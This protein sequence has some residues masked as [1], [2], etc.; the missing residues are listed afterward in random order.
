LADQD[1][2]CFYWERSF[3]FTPNPLKHLQIYHKL[4]KKP[5]WKD[6][7][8]SASTVTFSSYLEPLATAFLLHSY[9][10]KVDFL[11]DWLPV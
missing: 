8:C 11:A 9:V 3:S 1:E 6:S 5:I 10:L 4:F 2:Q 7:F